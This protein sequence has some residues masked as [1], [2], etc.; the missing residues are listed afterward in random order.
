MHLHGAREHERKRGKGQSKIAADAAKI[1]TR[2]LSVKVSFRAMLAI[3]IIMLMVAA[4]G[5]E[6]RKKSTNEDASYYWGQF[7][8][9]ECRVALQER[10]DRR[11]QPRGL[12]DTIQEI[13]EHYIEMTGLQLAEAM[14]ISFT[15]D[16]G[17][18][19]KRFPYKMTGENGVRDTIK[20]ML[21]TKSKDAKEIENVRS[22]CFFNV[23]LIPV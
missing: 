10:S 15:Q 6:T 22:I 14:G 4:V 12:C 17:P 13:L 9:R 5:G 11:E 8:F 2:G 21:D 3:I 16:L 1:L 7:A 18:R 19:L 20:K 23:L